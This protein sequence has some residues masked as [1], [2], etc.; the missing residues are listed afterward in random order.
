MAIF[1][2][3]HPARIAFFIV[4]SLG[5]LSFLTGCANTLLLFPSQGGQSPPGSESK[6]LPFRDGLLE[7]WIHRAD[8]PN[9]PACFVLEF[10][11]NATR[12]ENVI[13]PAA[14]RWRDQG[15]EVWAMNYPGFGRS[16]GPARLADIPPATLAAFDA[17]AERAKGKPIF[18]SGRSMGTTAALYLAAHRPVSGLL[19]HNPPPLREVIVHHYGWWNLWL[20]A[21]IVAL[22]V[23][24]DLDSISNAARVRAPAIFILADRDRLVPPRFQREIVDAFAGVKRTVTLQNAG[25]DSE[26]NAAEEGAI[27]AEIRWMVGRPRVG[28][29]AAR[30]LISIERGLLEDADA[31]ARNQKITRSQLFRRGLKA[32][33]AMA[34]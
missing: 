21:G 28:R 16:T 15:A 23:P 20:A 22:Q 9:E 13:L 4:A 27:Q 33:L 17:L 31:L 7:I 30:V 2:R 32:V 12:A 10:V 11:G 34:G 19:L 26:P 5:T 18:V 24:P 6:V 29:G 1:F 3:M 14:R 8:P 25:H